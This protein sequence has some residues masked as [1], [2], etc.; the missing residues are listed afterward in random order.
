MYLLLTPR[1]WQINGCLP[2]L[3]G[4]PYLIVNSAAQ[5]SFTQIPSRS[6]PQ[7]LPRTQLVSLNCRLRLT[8]LLPT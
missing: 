5:P 6:T 1:G 8:L 2:P 3:R 7:L 4:Y